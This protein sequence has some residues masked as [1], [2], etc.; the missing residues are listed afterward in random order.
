MSLASRIR[1]RLNYLFPPAPPRPKPGPKPPGSFDSATRPHLRKE[2]NPIHPDFSSGIDPLWPIPEEAMKKNAEHET[3]MTRKLH[4]H[5]A[6][7]RNGFGLVEIPQSIILPI[8]A[9]VQGS[10]SS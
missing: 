2:V 3:S 9:L 5:T 8:R 1:A 10:Q 4:P 6:F 7:G